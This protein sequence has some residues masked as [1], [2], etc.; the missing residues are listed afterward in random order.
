MNILIT[1]V[2]R[3]SYMIQYFRKALMNQGEV[4]VCNSDANTVS[5]LYADKYTISPLIYDEQYIPFLLNYCTN[6]KIDMLISLFDIDLQVL[7]RNKDKFDKIG[8]KVIVSNSDIIEI[9]NDK[10]KTYQFLRENGFAV[11]QTFLTLQDTLSAIKRGALHYPVIVKP[12]FGCGSIAISIA[13]DEP[14]LLYYSEHIEHEIAHSYLKY[15]SASVAEKVIYQE[16]LDG[17]EHGADIINDLD[18]NFRNAVLRKKIAMRAG[19]TDIAE[20][21]EDCTT[22]RVMQKLGEVTHHIA[23]MDCD[24]FLVDGI[25]YILEL[26]ARFGGGYPF[27]HIAGCNLPKAIIAWCNGEDVDDETLYARYGCLGF[28]ELSMTCMN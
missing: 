24:Y 15:E 3:R 10:Y 27:S 28:K 7:A 18:G 20:I 25:P 22:Y 14:S 21:I 2:G 4:H 12:R 9:C 13:K 26:N 19:E 1:S 8:T 6:H 17:Q 16:F 23:N 5:F 11:P